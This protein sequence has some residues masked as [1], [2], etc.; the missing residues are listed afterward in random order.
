MFVQIGLPLEIKRD[1]VLSNE[2]ELMFMR[3]LFLAN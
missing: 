1:I 3:D 2:V